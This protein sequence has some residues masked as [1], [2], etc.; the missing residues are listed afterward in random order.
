MK[1]ILIHWLI[2]LFIPIGFFIITIIQGA[3][4]FD[5]RYAFEILFEHELFYLV[6]LFSLIY[7]I[8]GTYYYIKRD[9]EKLLDDNDNW[10]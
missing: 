10:D 7:G 2:T 8:V 1:K 4:W 3:Y 5:I 6:L 9:F